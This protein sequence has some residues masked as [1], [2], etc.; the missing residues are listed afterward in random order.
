MISAAVAAADGTAGTAAVVAAAA[1][2]SSAVVVTAAGRLNFTEGMD[3]RS[4]L[5]VIRVMAGMNAPIA[6]AAVVMAMNLDAFILLFST[7]S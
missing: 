1:F 7:Y 5:S 3:G 4:F 6:A 2:G